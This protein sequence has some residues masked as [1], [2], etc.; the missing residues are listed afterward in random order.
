MESRTRAYRSTATASCAR[1]VRRSWPERSLRRVRTSPTALTASASCSPR[2]VAVAPSPSPVRAP[3]LGV[4][5]LLCCFPPEYMIPSPFADTSNLATREVAHGSQR[6]SNALVGVLQISF[7][8]SWCILQVLEVPSSS[9]STTATGTATASAAT[10]ATR[11]WWAEA[12]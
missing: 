10:S 4:K 12:S 1:T 3:R 5:M 8:N 11:R 9:L 2:S 7:K 6:S